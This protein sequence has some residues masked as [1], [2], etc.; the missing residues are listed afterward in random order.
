[1]IV[2]I[3]I[4]WFLPAFKAGGPIQSIA[5][6]VNTFTHDIEYRIFSSNKDLNNEAL[7]NIVTDQWIPFNTHT[8]V[9]Y[10]SGK[11]TRKIIVEQAKQIKPD[12]IFIIGL[13]SWH[14][15]IVP[16]LFCKASKKILSVRGMLH[17]GALTQ[18]KWK[19]RL[20]LQ[21]LKLF[22]I[23][24]NIVFHATDK[25]EEDFIKAAFGNNAIVA[26]AANF[27]HIL[28][29]EQ[30]LFKKKNYL[31]LTTI[32]LISPMKNHLLILK[33]LANCSDSITYNI[34]GP[35]KEEAY[36]QLCLQQINKL[37]KHIVVKYH[38]ALAPTEIENT[39]AQQHVFIM[40]S[41]SENFGHSIYEALSAGKPVITSLYTPWNHLIELNAGINVETDV[42]EIC[43]AINFFA[44][45]D[46]ESYLQFVYGAGTYAETAFNKKENTNAYNKL[47]FDKL[48]Q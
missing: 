42:D 10:A 6:L 25:A 35:I 7:I 13:F 20:F 11:N 31:I 29:Q 27:P 38:A 33:A 44:N 9:W 22:K 14:F 43:N 47:F 45:L 16:L 18:K 36:W 28:K 12:A 30:P 3:S 1:M 46:N 40:P 15:N 24:R 17:P 48:L 4:P 37:P 21:V 34:Y 32:A 8:K 2:F 26:V 39:L 19:K 5:N 41:K 23:K